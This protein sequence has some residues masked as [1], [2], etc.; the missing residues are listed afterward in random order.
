M[1]AVRKYKQLLTLTLTEGLRAER[2]CI[3]AHHG[4]QNREFL[5]VSSAEEKRQLFQI[6]I[7]KDKRNCTETTGDW[8]TILLTPNVVQKYKHLTVTHVHRITARHGYQN[9]KQKKNQT[10]L[11]TIHETLKKCASLV[12]GCYSFAVFPYYYSFCCSKGFLD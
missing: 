8:E 5:V 11:E 10:N 4:H 6:I 7:N 9:R 1:F 3:T 2:K 12:K